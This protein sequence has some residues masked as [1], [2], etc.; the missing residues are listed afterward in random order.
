M[1][2]SDD[3]TGGSYGDGALIRK[4]RVSDAHD[5]FPCAVARLGRAC[6]IGAGT[7]RLPALEHTQ[8][9]PREPPHCQPLLELAA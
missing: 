3:E 8:S 7:S 4:P 9:L 5:R 1:G 2:M 6:R